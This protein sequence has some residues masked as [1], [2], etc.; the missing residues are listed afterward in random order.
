MIDL[1]EEREER[2]L[3]E[4]L[5]TTAINQGTLLEIVKKPKK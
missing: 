2:E 5:A 4:I 1:K 3:E